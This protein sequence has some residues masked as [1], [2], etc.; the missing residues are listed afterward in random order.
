MN[1]D[2]YLNNVLITSTVNTNQGSPASQA[3]QRLIP[4][5]QQWGNNHL[6]YV[7][8]SGSYA[9]GTAVQGGTDVDLFISVSSQLNVT[10]KDIYR[11]LA[12]CLRDN[13]FTPREQNV[14]IGVPVNGMKVDLVPGKASA[15]GNN[16]HSLY[17]RKS[18]SWIKTNPQKHIEIVSQSL[19]TSEIKLFKIWRNN[20]SL[21]F[22]SFLLELV[23]I[24]AL[25][26]QHYGDFQQNMPI[27]LN[28]I[29]DKIQTVRIVDPANTNNVVSDEMTLNDKRLLSQAAQ[30]ALSGSW[31]AF[32]S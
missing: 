26:G 22:P 32:I 19:R 10:L 14:S 30:S 20:K 25:K 11:S 5:I 6:N 24:E 3:A 15:Q 31:G 28:Y 27:V 9:K 2:Q 1:T 8:L 23:V 21:E 12:K 29:K 13:G 18:D 7:S 17:K 4:Y 16:D